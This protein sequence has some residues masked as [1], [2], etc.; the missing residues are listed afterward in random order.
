MC[1][2]VLG[3]QQPAALLT[4]PHFYTYT[5]A[6]NAL[7]K[8]W[9][10]A[11]CTHCACRRPAA[12]HRGQSCIKRCR[13][14]CVLPNRPPSPRHTT[15][16][17]CPQHTPAHVAPALPHFNAADRVSRP[18]EHHYAGDL[19]K[20]EI[21][22]DLNTILNASDAVWLLERWQ[23]PP[24]RVGARLGQS[25]H[26]ATIRHSEY[27]GACHGSIYGSIC[28]HCQPIHHVMQNQVDIP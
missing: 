28:M 16:P 27:S 5:R 2:A 18:G 12:F 23:L 20:E 22:N 10:R 25:S 26:L 6:V 11:H 7:T 24:C 3:R 1:A 15:P 9:L 19:F 13:V 4:M 17:P 8:R 14:G 21:R